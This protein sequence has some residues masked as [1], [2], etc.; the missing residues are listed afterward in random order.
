MRRGGTKLHVIPASL[1]NLANPIQRDL[2]SAVRRLSKGLYCLVHSRLVLCRENL[3]HW[4]PLKCYDQSSLYHSGHR[5]VREPHRSWRGGLYRRRKMKTTTLLK[6]LT[7]PELRSMS[8]NQGL[9]KLWEKNLPLSMEV[10]LKASFHS[11]L[12]GLRSNS[13][14]SEEAEGGGIGVADIVVRLA[15]LSA[16]FVVGPVH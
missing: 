8:W 4:I 9:G 7:S 15:A 2:S 13:Q 12:M 11:D 16:I 1:I 6:V 3:S 10:R 14:T 5:P